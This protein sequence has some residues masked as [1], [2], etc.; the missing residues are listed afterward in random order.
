MDERSPIMERSYNTGDRNDVVFFTGV[1]IEH[2]PAYG[3]KTLFVVGIHPSAVIAAMAMQNQ[4]EHIYLGANQSF[5]LPLR[6]ESMAYHDACIAWERMA[7]GLLDNKFLVT[8]DFDVCYVESVLEMSLAEHSNFIPQVSVKIPYARQLG[9][10]ACIKI[11]DKDFKASNEGVWVHQL[12]D[13]MARDKFTD[14]SAY[15]KDQTL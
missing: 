10:N 13:L 12:H 2:T 11:D 1:E 7:K 6:G 14:W 3:K 9:Y 5:D 8:L 4:C 15:G